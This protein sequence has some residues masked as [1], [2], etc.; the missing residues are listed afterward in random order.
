[1][2]II[3][4][5]VKQEEQRYKTLGDWQFSGED[6][7]DLSIRVSDTGYIWY[8]YLLIIHELIEAIICQ[9][10]GVKQEVVDK[11]DIDHPDADEPGDLPGCPYKSAHKYAEYIE[12]SLCTMLEIKWYYYMQRLEEMWNSISRL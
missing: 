11:W 6:D 7:R 3:I 10:T 2:K 5:V 9:L 12:F 8:N 4:E 1:M